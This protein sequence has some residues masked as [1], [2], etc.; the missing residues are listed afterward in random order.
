MSNSLNRPSGKTRVSDSPIPWILPM[1]LLLAV[2]LVFPV[3]EIIRLSFTNASITT[4]AYKYT[5]DSYRHMLN[6][7]L[8]MQSIFTTLRFV[9]FSVVFQVSLGFI[10]A[11]SVVLGE[12]RN[13]KSS[14]AVRA[15]SLFSLM[16]PGAIIGVIWRM[17]FNES[18][19]GLLTY[20]FRVLGIGR[21]PFL[22]DGSIA[23]V[24]VVIAN[25]WRGTALCTILIYSGLKTIPQDIVEAARIDGASGFKVMLNVIL[26]SIRQIL[27]INILLSTIGTFNSF[28]MIMSLTRGGPGSATDVMALN[29]YNQ[30]F[31]M[32]DLGKGAAGGVILLL[33]NV[34]I[35]LIY[36]HYMNRGER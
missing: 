33:I 20:L 8:F 24:C 32:Y 34:M 6:D 15:V 35:A 16:I 12:E 4:G 21:V 31:R 17:I 26:P 22:S 2:A 36:Y 3:A 14:V 30:V 13:M 29:I 7:R 19:T 11:Y 9:F 27:M 1:Y 28:D 23:F 5:L 10:I 25:V 18:P